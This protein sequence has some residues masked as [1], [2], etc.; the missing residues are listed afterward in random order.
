MAEMIEKKIALSEEKWE[1]LSM[2]QSS[3]GKPSL[4]ETLN[5]LIQLGVLAVAVT[6]QT[7]PV[8]II[9]AKLQ[10]QRVDS[11]V[12]PHC[13]KEFLPLQKDLGLKQT[14]MSLK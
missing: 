5:M 3:L 1:E 9:S 14:M 13:G 8:V 11:V 7:R 4:V 10:G 6:D 12:C 2:I